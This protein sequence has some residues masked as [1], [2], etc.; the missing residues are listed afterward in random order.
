MIHL[1]SL[2]FCPWLKKLSVYEP[3]RRAIRTIVPIFFCCVRHKPV[4]RLGNIVPSDRKNCP[5]INTSVCLTS[6]PSVHFGQNLAV[7]HLFSLAWT[8]F[9]SVDSRGDVLISA[10]IS[11]TLFFFSVVTIREINRK[12]IE[13]NLT[14]ILLQ[15]CRTTSGN[16]SRCGN[17]TNFLL[18]LMV[19][20]VKT[21]V[22]G[23]YLHFANYAFDVKH[24]AKPL[25]LLVLRFDY[26][27]TMTGLSKCIRIG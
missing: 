5:K 7:E 19:M 15:R 25:L 22:L 12:V 14:K 17:A 9:N 21:A 20:F 16:N 2:W 4:I 10:H 13:V 6:R 27:K 23:G 26:M 24:N 18:F 1:F 3:A 8:C 11:S